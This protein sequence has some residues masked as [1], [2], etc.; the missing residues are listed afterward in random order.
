M[1]HALCSVCLC[2]CAL[3]SCAKT[4][5]LIEL[6]FGV[7]LTWSEKPYILDGSQD[8]THPFAAGGDKSV[9]KLLPSLVSSSP[10]VVSQ[11]KFEPSLQL[12]SKQT[13]RGRTEKAAQYFFTERRYA[14]AVYDVVVCPSV[15]PSVTRRYCTKRLNVCS[16]KQR[17][18]RSGALVFWSQRSPRNSIGSH[19]RG[20][21]NTGEVGYNWRFS[22][23][24][25]PYL[26]NSIKY[27][28]SYYETLI[29]TLCAVSNSSNGA[30]SSD[31]QWPVTTQ[32]IPV[33]SQACT[34][35]KRLNRSSSF[36]A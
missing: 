9:L 14:S 10:P 5:E 7:W 11:S 1:S 18:R 16:R 19:R 34:V 35:G 6:P 8:R 33:P 22:T 23:N 3:V 25:T 31:L 27:R 17:H 24:I 32:T 29:E 12:T 30:I 15:C 28:Q 13:Y 36:L 4:A 20:A 21:P 2:V 26:K